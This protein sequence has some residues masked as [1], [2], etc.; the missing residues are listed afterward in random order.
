[1]LSCGWKTISLSIHVT[2]TLGRPSFDTV[3]L[4]SFPPHKAKGPKA[5]VSL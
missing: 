1:M 3:G 5:K 4:A 2:C